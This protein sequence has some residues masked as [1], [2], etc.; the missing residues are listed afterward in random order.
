MLLT[1]IT[2]LC[3]CVS[4]CGL[5]VFATA[6]VFFIYFSKILIFFTVKIDCAEKKTSNPVGQIFDVT[7]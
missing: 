1:E 2:T 5:I 6:F 3:F 7:F 4:V